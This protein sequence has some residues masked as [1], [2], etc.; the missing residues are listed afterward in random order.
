MLADLMLADEI[1]RAFGETFGEQYNTELVG[2][3]DEPE[4]LPSQGEQPARILFKEDFAASALHEI[5]HWCIAGACRR[6]LHDYGYWYQPDRDAM[7]QRRFEQAETRPQ[8]LE[9][10]LATAAGLPFRVSFDS[11]TDDA[12]GLNRF[13][14]S[15]RDASILLVERGLPPRAAHFSAVLA[16]QSGASHY[17]CRGHY[18]ALP[19]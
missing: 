11:F 13:R 14:T 17:L 16:R 18:E 6:R 2:G 5:A 12:Q 3:G 10:V 4:Y 7:A 19:Q 1:V 8:A 9:R 15:V